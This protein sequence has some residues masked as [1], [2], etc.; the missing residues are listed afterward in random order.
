VG[1]GKENTFHTHPISLTHAVLLFFHI[2]SLLQN[3][4]SVSLFFSQRKRKTNGYF[5]LFT[6][7]LT[8]YLWF[9]SVLEIC[10]Y[11][12]VDEWLVMIKLHSK[13][14]IVLMLTAHFKTRFYLIV[15][16]YCLNICFI[17]W[18]EDIIF[19]HGIRQQVTSYLR[20][21]PSMHNKKNCLMWEKFIYRIYSLGVCE[22]ILKQAMISDHT[23]S[24]E[25]KTIRKKVCFISH[26]P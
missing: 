8:K 24:V 22:H 1:E 2:N 10:R 12:P 23:S 3:Y 14:P 5:H 7:R 11:I 15:N 21:Y 9:I 20:L 4:E 13:K 6:F 19:S 26:S 25:Y 17:S 18:Y 16:L